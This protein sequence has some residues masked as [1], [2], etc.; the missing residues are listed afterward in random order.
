MRIALA[1]DHGG[2]ELKEVI[3][4]H[5]ETRGYEVLDL[6][7]HTSE[8]VDY[9]SYAKAG[10]EAVIAGEAEKAIVFCG[11]GVGVSIAANKV[12]GI[13]CALCTNSF[14]SKMASMHNNANALALGGRVLG[15]ELAKDIVDAWLDAEFEGGRHER[16]T[17]MLDDM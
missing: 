4:E 11:T 16:R 1:A 3:K 6:G 15:T 17:D 10:A 2:Y 12:K 9:P 14:M 7:T 8:S 13:R 5:L